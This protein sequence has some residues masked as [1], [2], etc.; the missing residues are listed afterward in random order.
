MISPRMA[1][2][3]SALLPAA[4]VAATPAVK[5]APQVPEKPAKSS[6]I[7]FSLFPKSLQ[8]NPKLDFNIITE[9]SAEGRKW[10][11][12]TA[13]HPAYYVAQPGGPYNGGIG[14]IHGIKAPPVEKLQQMMEKSLAEGG[15]L[16]SDGA[17][18]PPTIVVLYHWG[19]HSF[20]PDGDIEG[21]DADGNATTTQTIPE[22]ELRKALMDRAMLLGGI[23]FAKE[24]ARAMEETDQKA[25]MS[26]NAAPASETP[27]GT[28]GDMMQNPFDRLRNQSLEMDRL[29]SELFSSSFFVVASAYD[30]AAVAKG[31]RHLLWR[32]KMTVN[33]TGINMVESVPSLI[34]SAGPYYGRELVDPVVITKRVSRDGKVEV[35][36]PTVVPD[37][38]PP[39]QAPAPA[40][41]K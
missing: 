6:P 4:L 13:E 34:A 36:T 9:M 38:P 21:T 31:Q 12:P 22:V 7:V 41:K 23:K 40:G 29:V 26:V 19:S 32:T 1:L 2:L 30:Y 39:A 10:P 11:I 5:V 17:A 37:A 16:V 14:A 15:Y 28:I 35:G 25:A 20:Q 33:S 24:V 8:R 18:H 27:M 3:F